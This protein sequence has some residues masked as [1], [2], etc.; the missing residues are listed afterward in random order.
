MNHTRTIERGGDSGRSLLPFVLESDLRLATSTD[1]AS[2]G[3]ER[4]LDEVLAD[5]FPASDPPSW[6]LG[7]EAPER[8]A[9]ASSAVSA[10]ATGPKSHDAVRVDVADVSPQGATGRLILRG[11]ATLAGAVGIALLVPLAILLVG[12]PIVLVIRGIAEAVGW[13]LLRIAG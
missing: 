8:P 13:L 5:S 2:Y 10:R 4:A 12:L 6:T 11:V 3:A 9:D 1:R 7:V